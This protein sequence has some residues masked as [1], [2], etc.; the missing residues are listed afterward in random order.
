MPLLAATLPL[1]AIMMAVAA[2]LVRN[3]R[4]YVEPPSWSGTATAVLLICS[5]LIVPYLLL[6]RKQASSVMGDRLR[7]KRIEPRAFLALSGMVMFLA[8]TCVALAL[9][10]LGAPLILLYVTT[11]FSVAGMAVW[12]VLYWV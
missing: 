10:L 1:A 4:G 12:A 2:T 3:D 9:S 11:V 7:A 5:L 6:L 8:P